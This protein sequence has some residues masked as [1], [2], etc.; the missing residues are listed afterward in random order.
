MG[1]NGI[2]WDIYIY[3]ESIYIYISGLLGSGEEPG[4]SEAISEEHHY[5][6]PKMG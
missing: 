6:N 5:S 4:M 2:S 3:V 1:Y